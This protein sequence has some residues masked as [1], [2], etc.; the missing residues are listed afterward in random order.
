M[1]HGP[2]TLVKV[3]PLA[4]LEPPVAVNAKVEPYTTVEA[5]EI[6]TALWLALEMTSVPEVLPV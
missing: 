5:L 2:D 4:L 3:Y 1:V 6:E